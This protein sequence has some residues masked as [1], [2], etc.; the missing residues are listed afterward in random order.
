MAARLPKTL[1]RSQYA[2]LNPFKDLGIALPPQL[3]NAKVLSV[4][5]SHGGS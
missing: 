1:R 5:G 3:R 4:L 2:M